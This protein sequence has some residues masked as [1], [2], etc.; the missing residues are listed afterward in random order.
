MESELRGELGRQGAAPESMS[1]SRLLDL[2]YLGQS[3]ELR[4]TWPGPDV[5]EIERM[6]H[7][8]HTKLYGFAVS[9]EAV[10]LVALRVSALGSVGPPPRIE[11]GAATGPIVAVGSRELITADRKRNEEAALIERSALAAGHRLDGPALVFDADATT[12]LPPAWR[13]ETDAGANLV[14]SRP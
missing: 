13:L 8:L 7:V 5:E 4:A 2:R 3:F 6:F 1:V 14:L 12:Y 9:T 11:L 10:E